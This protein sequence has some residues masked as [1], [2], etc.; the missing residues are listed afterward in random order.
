M[1][2]QEVVAGRKRLRPGKE[3]REPGWRRGA[4]E[5]G[6]G[7]SEDC[8]AAQEEEEEDRRAQNLALLAEKPAVER[9]LEELVFG[10]A[11]EGEDL[12]RRLRGASAQ[13]LYI[14]G[15]LCPWAFPVNQGGGG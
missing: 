5:Q 3:R 13:V 15:F 10:G 12:L 2:E 14:S 4:V 9:G 7:V 1:K 8:L 6:D 11:E